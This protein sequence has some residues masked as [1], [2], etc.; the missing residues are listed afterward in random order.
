MLL[1]NLV[2]FLAVYT[3]AKRLQSFLLSI[4][5]DSRRRSDTAFNAAVSFASNTNWQSYGESTMSHLTQMAG[6]T[7]QN[8]ASAA[9]GMAVLA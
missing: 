3:P 6:L 8:F 7:V 2:G 4:R 9:T 1:F 5:R